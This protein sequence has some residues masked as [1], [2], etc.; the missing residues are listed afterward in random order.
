MVLLAVDHTIN[1]YRVGYWLG[2]LMFGTL[3]F[4][5]GRGVQGFRARKE[6]RPVDYPDSWSGPGEA[7]P[8]AP[9]PWAPPPSMVEPTGPSWSTPLMAGGFAF[10]LVAQSVLRH[11]WGSGN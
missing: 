4:G 10:A 1:A 6:R 7:A 8:G 3:V 2:P 11:P 9:P 5:V